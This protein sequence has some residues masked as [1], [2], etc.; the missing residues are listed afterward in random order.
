MAIL[1]DCSRQDSFQFKWK[2][3]VVIRPYPRAG[4][5]NLLCAVDPFGGLVKPM[6]PFFEKC[7]KVHK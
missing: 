2:R 5:L 7:I 3:L 4:V 1:K 6:V